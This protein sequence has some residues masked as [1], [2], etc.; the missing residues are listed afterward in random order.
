M[1]LSFHSHIGAAQKTIRFIID[2]PSLAYHILYKLLAHKS[3]ILNVLDATPSYKELGEGFIAFLDELQSHGAKVDHIFFDGLLP[4][5]KQ[6]TRHNRQAQSLKG[7]HLFHATHVIGFEPS[8]SSDV[9]VLSYK[10]QLLRSS[11]K[12]PLDFRNILPPA[13]L[14]PAI[15]D[16]L[17]ASHYDARTRLV[18]E[19]ADVSCARAARESGGLILTSDSDML[20]YDLGRDGAVAF[21]SGLQLVGEVPIGRQTTLSEMLR[22]S[23]WRPRH[24]ASRLDLPDLTRLAYQI[25]QDP[26]LT[27]SET[28]RRVRKSEDTT[29]YQEFMK[30]YEFDPITAE[31]MISKSDVLVMDAAQCQHFDPRV[32]QS[33]FQIY[34]SCRFSGNLSVPS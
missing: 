20:V 26:H 33:V 17:R 16:T 31:E 23:V 30:E 19:E 5:W 4:P 28:I 29:E 7:L 24:I 27:L 14:V 1:T 9:P 12:A 32:S 8:H 13:F 2:G 6:E 15:L 10:N 22:M 3:P 18:P 25:S 21:L 11:R 34:P